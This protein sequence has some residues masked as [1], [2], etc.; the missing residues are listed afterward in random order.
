MRSCFCGW[1]YR[2]QSDRQTLVVIP[3]V[4]HTNES[5]FSAIQ[6]ITDTKS[7]HVPFSCS[8]FQKQGN[9][10]RI[11]GSRFGKEGITPDIQTPE[12][13]ATGS[14]RFGPF[15]PS[16]YDIMGPFRYV[17]F[18]QCRHRVYSMQ[19]CV[20]GTLLIN[21]TPYLLENA[22]GYLEGD[23]GYSFPRNYVWTQCSFPDGAWR[24]RLWLPPCPSSSPS[25]F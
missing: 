1:Y 25:L 17:P 15:T 9:H 24:V 7:F 18:L 13:H 12:L 5:S 22:I 19:H 11:A 2:C 14:V 20:D 6:L 3:S 21:G 23:R 10:I 16:G 8:D 4:H